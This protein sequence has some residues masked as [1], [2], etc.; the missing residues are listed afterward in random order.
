MLTE[1]RCLVF[2]STKVAYEG[3]SCVELRRV[4]FRSEARSGVFAIFW[5]TE[6]RGREG[7][8]SAVIRSFGGREGGSEGAR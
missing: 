7:G 6:G 2:V 5:D 8:S 1:S 4:I 3:T